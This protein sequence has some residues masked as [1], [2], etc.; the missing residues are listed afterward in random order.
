[1]RDFGRDA[2]R[3]AC[4]IFERIKPS[5]QA[6]TPAIRILDRLM[7]LNSLPKLEA[8]RNFCFSPLSVIILDEVKIMRAIQRP[9]SFKAPGPIAYQI[10][11][12]LP[13]ITN[14]VQRMQHNWINARRF[15]ECLIT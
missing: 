13:G 9:R 4:K 15:S 5:S 3:K 14:T 12:N 11:Y 6:G 1:M 10:A 8:V 7:K 2:K